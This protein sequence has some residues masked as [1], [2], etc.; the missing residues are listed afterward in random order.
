LNEAHGSRGVVAAVPLANMALRYKYVF[1]TAYCKAVIS[2]FHR[3]RPFYLRLHYQ[4]AAIAVVVLLAWFSTLAVPHSRSALLISACV[5]GA[6]ILGFVFLVRA[7]AMM[8]LRGTKE[9]GKEVTIA[10]SDAGLEAAGPNGHSSVKWSAYPHSVRF[11]DGIL[12]R[13]GGAIRW[14][15]DAALEEGSVQDALALIRSKTKL[16]CL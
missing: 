9:F 11:S 4:F 7:T 3:Q 5:T 14:L 13:R 8:K 6:V 1:D 10:L 2:R 12:L 15:P 16:R